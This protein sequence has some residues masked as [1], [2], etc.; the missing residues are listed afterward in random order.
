MRQHTSLVARAVR[1]AL[2]VYAMPMGT[3]SASVPKARP[4]EPH[5]SDVVTPLWRRPVVRT[6]MHRRLSDSLSTPVVSTK[7]KRVIV[8][9]GEG[10]IYALHLDDGSVMWRRNY[11]APLVSMAA[12]YEIPNG[13]DQASQE[14]AVMGASDGMLLA[15]AVDS[16][17]VLWKV[18]LDFEVTAQPT[19]A[20]GRLYI[21][22]ESNQVVALDAKTGEQLW[23]QSRPSRLSL[24]MQ[25]HGRATVASGLVFCSFSDG[26]AMALREETGQIEW[27]RPLSLRGGSFIDADATPVV[28]DE[29]VFVASLTDGV[30]AL[31]IKGGETAW[32]HPLTDVVSLVHTGNILFAA[33]TSG[34]IYLLDPRTGALRNQVNLL[35]R[36]AGALV[37]L[38]DA[39]A[40][41]CGP[42][43]LVLLSPV[44]GK[45][46][47]TQSMGGLPGGELAFG[48]GHLAHLTRSGHVMLWQ[49]QA[50]ADA[51]TLR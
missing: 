12:L 30:Y 25:G 41:T 24:T 14:V 37:D 23:S 43:G 47:G 1:V 35:A 26:F 46:V 50:D 39:V 48:G 2:L 19:Y 31:S 10:L 42:L 49:H 13:P 7:H 21:T 3:A 36:P 38:G 15:V 11:R 20:S 29:H 45:P 5:V 17:A 6:G 33:N 27:S 22:S 40:L 4:V 32:H 18:F 51:S 9:T 16:G 28:A 44:T 34:H 8:G